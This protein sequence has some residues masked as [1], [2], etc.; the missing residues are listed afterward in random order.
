M[1]DEKV[2]EVADLVQM[3]GREK[4]FDG[5]SFELLAGECLGVFGLRGSGKTALLHIVA[6]VERFKSG[7]ITVLGDDIRKS[8]KYKKHI[9]L[10]TQQK[11]LFQDLRAGENVDFIATLKGVDGQDIDSLVDAL[12]LRPYLAQPVGKIDP[13]VYQ[14]LA[15]ACALIG[16]PRILI[17]DQAIK[18]IDLN[19]RYIIK[20]VVREFLDN[21]GSCLCSFSSTEYFD[22]M[23]RIAW[24]ENGQ[25]TLLG[26]HVAQE[27]WQS[28]LA[29]AADIESGEQDG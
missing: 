16:S 28:M 6:G 14:R 5:L 19:S 25:V 21:G 27:R 24:L 8:Q 22:Y 11:S 23:D 20:H 4:V 13:G 29:A 17:A 3:S 1:S 15:L 2:I 12:E 7:K 26:P 10:I 18:D 9:G